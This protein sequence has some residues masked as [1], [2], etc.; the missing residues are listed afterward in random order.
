MAQGY[1]N[2]YPHF[3]PRESVIWTAFLASPQNVYTDFDY[4]VRVGKGFDPGPSYDAQTRQNAIINS[5]LRLDA[6]GRKGSEWWIFEVGVAAG[7]P[8]VGQLWQ[9]EALYVE[10]CPQN[11]PLKLC[12][13]TNQAK[14]GMVALCARKEILLLQ[15]PVALPPYYPP[16]SFPKNQG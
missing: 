9:Y 5:Q 8:K 16:G 1:G 3:L 15:F 12:V 10:S 11:S 13:V 4:D 14:F 6:V 7:A 2:Y